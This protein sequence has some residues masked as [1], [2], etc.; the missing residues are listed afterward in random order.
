[1]WLT[2]FATSLTTM[3]FI[4]HNDAYEK[5][6]GELLDMKEVYPEY[7]QDDIEKQSKLR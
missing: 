1:M 4:K 3:E 5:A 7:Y 2:M 6:Y